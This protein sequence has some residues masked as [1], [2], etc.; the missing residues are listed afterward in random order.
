[1]SAPVVRTRC[2]DV[3]AV[4]LLA[5]WLTV[6]MSTTLPGYL[7]LLV[8]VANLSVAETV[9][10][11]GVRLSFGEYLKTGPWITLISLGL[12]WLLV[13]SKP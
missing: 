12:A 2:I 8:S 6:A 1:M 13:C 11:W 10:Q 9:R 7:T 3:P 5:I 4:R